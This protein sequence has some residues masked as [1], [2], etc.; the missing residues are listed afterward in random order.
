M[1]EVGDVLLESI[2]GGAV[3]FLERCLHE[4]EQL[5]VGSGFGVKGV[6]GGFEDLGE[7]LKGLFRVGNGGI[8]HLVV[9]CFCI[10][11]LLFH[12]SSYAGWS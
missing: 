3:L 10:R 5:S 9:P 7:L 6:A 4:R 8:C 12:C 2:I 1:L 11:G